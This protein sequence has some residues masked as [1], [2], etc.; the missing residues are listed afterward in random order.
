M[1][2]H[3]WKPP[4]HGGSKEAMKENGHMD[5]EAGVGMG[6]QVARGAQE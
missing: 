3:N 4:Q 6:S 5:P 2:K 1:G